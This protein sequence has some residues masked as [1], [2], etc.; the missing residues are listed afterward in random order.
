MR[1][2]GFFHDIKLMLYYNSSEVTFHNMVEKIVAH[3]ESGTPP[4]V[5]EKI[6][7]LFPEIGTVNE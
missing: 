2:F 4:G 6:V 3:A 1:F 5:V 7:P